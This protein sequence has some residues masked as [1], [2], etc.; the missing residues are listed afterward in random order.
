MTGHDLIKLGVPEG[1][2]V[3]KKFRGGPN[4]IYAGPNN[5]DLT[6]ILTQGKTTVINKEDYYLVKDYKWCAHKCKVKGGVTWYVTTNTIIN[7]KRTTID[8]HKLI[9]TNC[10]HVDHK[11]CDG[12]NNRRINLRDASYQQNNINRSKTKDKSVSSKFKGVFHLKHLNKWK[13]YI[14]S[15]SKYYHIGV[16]DTELEAAQAYDDW[17]IKFF[18]EFAKLNKLNYMEA[19]D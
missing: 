9:L 7:G 11:D 4:K 5:N 15:N 17:A 2:E 16:F 10:S 18:E 6:I 13:A 19:H 1:P 14:T 3:G 12:L 8:L